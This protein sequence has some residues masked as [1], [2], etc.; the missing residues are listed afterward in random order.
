MTNASLWRWGW[1]RAW[2]TL[3]NGRL[4]YCRD[5]G[6][7]LKVVIEPISAVIFAEFADHSL[8]S[9]ENR[10]RINNVVPLPEYLSNQGF[11]IRRRYDEMDVCS[12]IR[13]TACPNTPF[14]TA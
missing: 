5:A 9:R 6:F 12:T 11:V 10:V 7:Q 14:R 2:A 4:R 8:I 1:L 3:R 13:Q